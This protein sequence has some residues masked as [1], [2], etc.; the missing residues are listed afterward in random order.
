MTPQGFPSLQLGFAGGTPCPDQFSSKATLICGGAR[1]LRIQSSLAAIVVQ[2]G[3]GWGSPVFGPEETF[4]PT[5]GSIARTFDAVRVRNFIAGQ[6]A[7]VIL[8][9]TL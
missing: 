4:Y 3:Y 9:P 1:K 2:F 5:V 8:T 6:A 7:Q